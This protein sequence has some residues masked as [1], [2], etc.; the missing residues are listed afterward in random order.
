[1][2]NIN[3]GLFQHVNFSA[4][5]N[6]YFNIFTCYCFLTWRGKAG[7]YGIQ[8]VASTFVKRIEGDYNNIIGLPLYRIT[9]KLKELI[10]DQ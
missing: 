8:G 3:I 10:L 7:G 4:K 5:Y 2:C 9:Q 6:D 1:M